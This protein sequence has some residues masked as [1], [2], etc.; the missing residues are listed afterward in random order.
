MKYNTDFLFHEHKITRNLL[1]F[2]QDATTNSCKCCTLKN[3]FASNAMVEGVCGCNCVQERRCEKE[4]CCKCCN[5]RS[6][7]CDMFPA[8]KVF[9]VRSMLKNETKWSRRLDPLNNR[10]HDMCWESDKNL[11][12]MD[13][14]YHFYVQCLKKR[15]SEEGCPC[16]PPGAEDIAGPRLGFMDT[17]YTRWD[18]Q[19]TGNLRQR[20]LQRKVIYSVCMCVCVCVCMRELIT[21]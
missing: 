19:D 18:A 17:T 21:N 5:D 8:S 16:A 15:N 20:I 12:M 3:R 6:W 9:V 4:C 10:D 14:M 7:H 11:P 2:A 13:P 1:L